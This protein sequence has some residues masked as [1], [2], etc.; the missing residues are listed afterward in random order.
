MKKVVEILCIC[1]GGLFAQSDYPSND[2]S[3]V[4][5]ANTQIAEP[6]KKKDNI[7]VFDFS[8]SGSI[9]VDE[10]K[11]ITDRFQTELIKIGAFIVLERA[12]MNTILSEQGFQQSGA[13]NTSDC[14]V[15]IGQLLGVDKLITG[16]VGKVGTIYTMNLKLINIATGTIEKSQAQDFVGGMEEILTKGCKAL[17]QELSPMKKEAVPIPE[18]VIDED[19]GVS[20]WWWVG[21]GVVIVGGVIVTYLLLNQEIA[22]DEEACINC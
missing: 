2:Q 15:E 16:S 3:Q 20:V 7:A 21:G 19:E 6:I 17:A 22:Q 9:P 12:E 8:T 18:D 1:F 14:Q 10:V 4:S 11:V 5:A 13:C